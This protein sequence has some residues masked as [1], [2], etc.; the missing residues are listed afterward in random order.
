MAV[1][2]MSGAEAQLYGLDFGFGGSLFGTTVYSTAQA[3]TGA[4]SIRCNPASGV[5]EYVVNAYNSG[6]GYLH[7]G[8]RIASLPSVSRRVA[9]GTGGN[10]LR[11][12]S[13]GTIEY[14]AH[15][16]L[17]G[18]SSALSLNTW[19]WIGWV[20]EASITGDLL[21]IDGTAAVTGTSSA[22]P[23]NS[24][25]G[26]NAGEASAA[27]IYLDDFIRDDAGLLAPS[28]VD[29][30]LPIS[31]NTRTAVTGGAGG[32]TNL[33][34][35]VNNTPP[36]GVASASETN[37][38][39]I[40]YPASATESYIANLETYTTLGVGSNDTIL[41]TRGII[42]H[43]EDIT[44][45]TKNGTYVGTT[46][47]TQ[48]DNTAFVFGANGGAHA[49]E[50]GANFWVTLFGTLKTT[51]LP[52]SGSFGT[53]PTIQVDRVSE[54]RVGCIDFMGMHVAW[55][56]GAGGP[57]ANPPYRNPMIQLLPQ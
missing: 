32:T 51:S 21:A 56:P 17:V 37:L 20:A 26:F 12:T 10:H 13:S 27:D 42:R 31:D 24:A 16:S 43:G 44:T 9:G 54:S 35:A 55:T 40:E 5:D 36:A 8:L 46:N 4:S 33:W 34:D 47:P 1:T 19:Y 14:W 50:S 2:S 18:A 39:N 49:A 25:V 52:T 7:F 57:A 28:K 23:G 48:T 38:T 45:G 30:A 53:S 6:G 41:A 3:R 29:T 11:L 15:T 22:N